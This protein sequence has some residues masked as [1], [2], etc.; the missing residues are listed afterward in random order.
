MN[1]KEFFLDWRKILITIVLFIWFLVGA[2]FL[3]SYIDS[4][5]FFLIGFYI[6]YPIFLIFGERIFHL[7]FVKMVMLRV[8]PLLIISEIIMLGIY[9]FL[10][11]CLI[12]WIYDKVKKK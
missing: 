2:Y 8:E 3:V 4:N 1:W 10:I 5:P 11:S 6:G 7:I 9:D 12:V